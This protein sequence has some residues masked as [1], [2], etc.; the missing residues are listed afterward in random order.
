MKTSK[1]PN[2]IFS[3]CEGAYITK[4]APIEAPIMELIPM[5]T[6]KEEI[7]DFTV[8]ILFLACLVIPTIMVGKLMS[9]LMVPAN[10]TS[11]PN[12]KQGVCFK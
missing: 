7:S 8:Y 3:N 1:P 12:I 4:N 9:K 11:I 10:L 5:G 6:T 2:N